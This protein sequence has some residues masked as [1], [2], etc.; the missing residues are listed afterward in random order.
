MGYKKS[1]RSFEKD[2]QNIFKSQV[3]PPV[4]NFMHIA[5]TI[6]PIFSIVI[7]GWLIRL[8][9]FIPP[10]FL[11]PA[12]RLVFYIAIPAMIFRA[13]SKASF[14]AQ[15]NLTIILITLFSVLA[16]FLLS[17]IA[18]R[19]AKIGR[20]NLGT[21]IQASVHG[22][23][24]YIGFAVVYYHM[25]HE[26]FIKAGIIGGFVMILQNLLAVAA[27]VLNNR[28]ASF[29]KNSMFF[30]QKIFGNPVILSSMAGI[31]FSAAEVQVPD[32][33]GRILDILGSLTLPMALLVIGA[34]ISFKVMRLSIFSV[35]STSFFKLVFLP[36]TGYILFGI[37]GFSTDQYLP[38][39]I[40]LASPTATITYIMAK[41]MNG[42]ADF[43]VAAISSSTLISAL[44]FLMW[45][46]IAG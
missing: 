4:R 19:A 22:N 36:L 9:G 46:N 30:I 10:E 45:L 43:A 11:G 6:I 28:D 8:K 26:G 33:I 44:T 38:G 23:L 32:I 20:S 5:G 3:V 2:N 18:G 16:V 14:K 7:I 39:L 21:F 25:G 1:G 27:L 13:I 17:W 29:N 35:L 15:F 12:N 37:Y 31:L 41:E 24:G 34:S 42:N 40:L